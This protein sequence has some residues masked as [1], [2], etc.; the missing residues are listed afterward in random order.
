MKKTVKAIPEGYH[1]IT[2]YLIVNDAMKAIGFYKKVFGAKEEMRMDKPDGK[3]GHAEL[4]I[5]NSKIMLADEHPG[6]NA[7]SPTVD[8][9]SVGIHL[10]IEDVDD[11]AKKAARNGAMLIRPLEN[12]FYGDRSC[13]IKD[14]F[15]H[16]WYISTHIED[17]SHKELQRRTEALY[18]EKK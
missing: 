2:P 15:G 14:P 12:M 1:S 4:K 17:V 18:K 3:V 11:V 9:H 8:S 7:R 13:T 5:G 10:Y 16:I 6:M